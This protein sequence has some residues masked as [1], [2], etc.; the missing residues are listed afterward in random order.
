M[1]GPFLPFLHVPQA[2]DQIVV[3]RE[4]LSVVEYD[5]PIFP[6]NRLPPPLVVD[7]PALAND[8]DSPGCFPGNTH[9]DRVALLVR[10]HDDE[11]RLT[12]CLEARVLA[13]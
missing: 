8:C 6:R 9:M 13:H 11:F 3:Q 5:R 4:Y 2:I 12:E 10:A 1:L 7:L